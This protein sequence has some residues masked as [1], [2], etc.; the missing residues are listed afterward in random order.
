[1]QRRCLGPLPEDAAAY[2]EAR[3][4]GLRGV[5]ERKLEMLREDIWKHDDDDD[6]DDDDCDK[7]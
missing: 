5:S 7:S 4:E 6:D 1:M 3:A 2:C